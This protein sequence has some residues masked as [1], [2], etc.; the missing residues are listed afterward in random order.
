VATVTAHVDG[1]EVAAHPSIFF[2]AARDEIGRPFRASGGCSLGA[3]HAA[4]GL[5]LALALVWLSR[6]RRKSRRAA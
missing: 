4:S 1:I 6:P 5:V 2:V 3:G